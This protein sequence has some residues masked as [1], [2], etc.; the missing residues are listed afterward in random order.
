MLV[1]LCVFSPVA[2]VAQADSLETTEAKDW[3]IVLGDA[4]RYLQGGEKTPGLTQ[5]YLSLVRRV[6]VRADSAKAR[7]EEDLRLS[8]KLLKAIGPPPAKGELPETKEIDE[9]R[10]RYHRRVTIAR[11]RL[12]EAE[13]T[14]LRAGGLEEALSGVKLERLLKGVS[15]RLPVPVSPDV[16][17]KGVPELGARLWRVFLS[18]LDWRANLPPE[19]SAGAVLWPGIV[20]LVLGAFLGWGI[21]RKVLAFLGRDSGMSEP[22]YARRLGGAIAEG[23]ANGVLPGVVLAALYLWLTQP[24]ALVSGLF[25]EAL[26][27]FLVSMLFFCLVAA[28]AR[29][30]FSPDRPAWRLTGQSAENARSAYRLILVLA[31]IFSIDMFF[32]NLWGE[33]GGS[34]ESTSIYQAVFGV[35]EGWFFIR[36]GRGELWRAE[37]P[38]EGEG[39]PPGRAWEF[40]RRVARGLAMLGVAALFVGYGVFGKR[41]L[42]NLIL[43]SLLLFAA[44][45]LRRLLHELLSWSV[46]SEFVQKKLRVSS[47]MVE[48]LRPWVHV[49]LEAAV[50]LFGAVLIVVAWGAPPDDL[51]RWILRALSGFQIG[52][53]RISV[54]DVVLAVLTFFLVMAGA[55][56]LQMQLSERFLE[57]TNLPSSVRHSLNAGLSYVS[58]IFA[59]LLSVSVAGINLTN[60]ALVAGAIS[61]GVGFG[62]QNVVN[63]FVSG[64]ILLVERPIKV[65]DWVRVEDDEGIVKKVQFRATELETF[66]RASVII[67]NAKIISTSVLNLTHRDNYGRVEVKVGVAYG[68]D[69]EKVRE[70]LLDV[71]SKNER[72][73]D[74]PAPFVV[75]RDFGASS[76][77]FEVRCFT[78]NVMSRMGVGSDLRFTIER[79]FREEG[80]EIPFP[81]R[82][83][84]L[85]NPK[86]NEEEEA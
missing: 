24:G 47:P 14:I 5:G 4:T 84:N 18:P 34:P 71:A 81:Q 60:L 55:R 67:P 43:T 31:A 30:F 66:Q 61:V 3:G 15:R 41:L 39:L 73:S 57:Q 44:L 64:M 9:R 48:A 58:V 70:V 51:L 56:F 80:I 11:A 26:T 75:F 10:E 13:V 45:F 65:G 54:I 79:R 20:V 82:V 50:F 85:V 22:S 76:L 83:V 78:S 19:S 74:S 37:A 12:A 2:H 6:R 40:V 16:I 62:L 59:A 77:D 52:S 72:V 68:S 27:S 21:R 36:L 29:S 7:Y 23:G 17:R 25:A 53:I 46:R 69:V 32:S 35:L 63:N 1:V 42:A 33:E 49:I 86:E 8:E 28:F 38:Q